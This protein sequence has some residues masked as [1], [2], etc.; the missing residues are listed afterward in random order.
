V[1]DCTAHFRQPSARQI[2]LAGIMLCHLMCLV[3][4]LASPTVLG[5][6]C[7]PHPS[8]AHS[9]CF[10]SRPCSRMCAWQYSLPPAALD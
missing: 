8:I 3:Q 10:G 1:T 9:F 2:A 4:N 7:L 5:S 6:A